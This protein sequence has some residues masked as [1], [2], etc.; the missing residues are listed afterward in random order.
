MVVVKTC[1]FISSSNKTLRLDYKHSPTTPNQPQTS[2]KQT[3]NQSR[4]KIIDVYRDRARDAIEFQ[5]THW[6]DPTNSSARGMQYLDVRP[7]NL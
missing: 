4:W 1:V 6:A 3:P 7:Q 2:L 5:Y